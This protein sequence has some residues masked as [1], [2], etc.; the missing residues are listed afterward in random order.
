MVNDTN[1]N[2]YEY[3]KTSWTVEQVK[4]SEVKDLD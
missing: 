1:V 4:G 3:G 2:Q